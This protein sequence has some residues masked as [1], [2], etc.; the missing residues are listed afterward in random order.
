MIE[1]LTRVFGQRTL[2]LSE[3]TDF[4][5]RLMEEPW[6]WRQRLVERVS[7]G[8]GDHMRVSSSYQIDFPPGLIEAFALRS[9]DSV[10]VIVPLTTREKR[11]LL[12][13][14]VS[15]VNASS[16]I[17][18]LRQSIAAI[19]AEHMRRLAE[20]SPGGPPVAVGLDANLL[21]AISVF[22]PGLYESLLKEHNGNRRAA[23]QHYLQSGVGIRASDNAIDRWL[24]AADEAAVM[25]RGVDAA[26]ANPLSSSECIVLAVAHLAPY[27]QTSAQ[28]GEIV[29]R[30][31][32]AVSAAA[33][34][35]DDALLLRLLEYGSRWELMLELEVRVGRPFEVTV[36][37]D[38]P[39]R[40]DT[41]N[42]VSTTLGLHDA[43]SAHVEFSLLDP[44]V[45]ID[46]FDVSDHR[47]RPVALGLL[48]AI[49][50]TSDTLSLYSAQPERPRLAVV[51]VRLETTGHV[52]RSFTAATVVTASAVVAVALV[53]STTDLMEKLT[54]LAL[55]ASVAAA[56]V[57]VREQTNLATR[58]LARRRARLATTLVVLWLALAIRALMAGV[59]SE[60]FDA[61]AWIVAVLVD[62]VHAHY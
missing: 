40:L 47:G 41:D 25:L 51:R 1:R 16:P 10:N 21:E 62:Y 23:L 29:G 32:R 43:R 36:E 31:C 14:D 61:I 34:G 42:W 38:R 58:I 7:L 3:S 17:L 19:Q 6:D 49:R 55:P 24:S 15:A 28:V 50:Y 8:G 48:D 33:A 52:R 2:D 46:G 45:D 59:P 35:G 57:L 13:F 26:P 53:A 12:R 54:L 44:G 39:F 20:T 22:T 56:I 37:E 9:G 5:L 60:L 18:L 11:P 4:T 30:Y 27:P